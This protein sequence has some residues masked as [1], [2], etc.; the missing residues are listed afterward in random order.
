MAIYKVTDLKTEQTTTTDSLTSLFEQ[1]KL[2]GDTYNMFV[3]ELLASKRLQAN[4][5]VTVESVD[6][7][8]AIKMTRAELADATDRMKQSK[9]RLQTFVM[10]GL[11][12]LDFEDENLD[13]KKDV[14]AILDASKQAP[15]NIIKWFDKYEGEHLALA[16]DVRSE[17]EAEA[18]TR[19]ANRPTT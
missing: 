15:V 12:E 13:V 4:M 14:A 18:A 16:D 7:L 9:S 1:N 11:D 6:T 17:L 10:A 5:G 2:E 19:A 3:E 8:E